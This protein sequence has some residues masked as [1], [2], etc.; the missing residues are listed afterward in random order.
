M[1]KYQ[2]IEKTG[3]EL[4]SFKVTI[5]ADSNDGDYI[6]EINHYDQETFDKYII[7]GLI[8]LQ[9]NASESH[10]LENYDNPFDLDIPYNGWDGY[11]HTLEELIVEFID[12]DGKVWEVIF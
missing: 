12:D 11:C 9:E 2:L 4:N 3:K 5:V 6:T 8:H 1:E 10:E 7:D